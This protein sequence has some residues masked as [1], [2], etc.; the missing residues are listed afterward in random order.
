MADIIIKKIETSDYSIIPQLYANSFL[1]K[2]WP[3][4][5]FNISQFNKDTNWI[6]TIDDKATGFI[7]TFLDKSIPYISVVGVHHASQ[8]RGIGSKLIKQA[9]MYW[10]ERG[11]TNMK[12]HVHKDNQRVH[13]LYER[14]GFRYTRDYEDSIEMIYTHNNF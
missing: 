9:M 12:I 14:L 5:W 1:E 7:I 3:V 13:D 11:Y 10:I 4:N 2:P 6:A 8:G